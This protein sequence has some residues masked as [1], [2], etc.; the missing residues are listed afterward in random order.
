M[1][2]C[3]NCNG[4]THTKYYEDQYRI[5]AVSKVCINPNCGWES[6]KTKIPE[7]LP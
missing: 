3:F 7:K 6:F 5:H 4:P 1:M 2:K